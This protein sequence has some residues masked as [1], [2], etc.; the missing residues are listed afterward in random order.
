MTD[1]PRDPQQPYGKDPSAQNPGDPQGRPDQRP[2]PRYG[3]YASPDQSAGRSDQAGQP[4]YGQYAPP[5]YGQSGAYGQQ[6]P[7][8]YGQPPQQG[9]PYG[10]PGPYQQ[11]YGQSG[12]YQQSYGQ[13]GY[14]MH[15]GMQQG[16]PGQPAGPVQ[17]PQSIDRSYWLILAAG[18][19][20]GILNLVDVFRPNMG[21]TEQDVEMAN[22][23]LGD[24]AMTLDFEAM[25][26]TMRITAVVFTLVF[27]GVYLLIA[28]GIRNGSNAA[29]II[30]T[31]L[32]V[33]SVFMIF[34]WG[35]LY[36]V[37]GIVGIV[38]A[39]LHPSSEYMRARAW[40]KASGYR[41]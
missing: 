29:R 14:G 6:A 3:Q 5:P 38:F 27:V 26:P 35:F 15:P 40:E 2:Q 23:M 32:A 18:A 7:G 34:G 12:P 17:R 11:P 31:V 10:Q 13:P 39:Y 36:V 41:R 25:L 16:M 24:N 4:Q 33:L 21:M 30:G 22:D 9:Q 1:Q 20:F 28:R 8:P 37:P 19:I